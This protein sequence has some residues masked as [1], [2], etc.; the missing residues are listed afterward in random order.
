MVEI[1]TEELKQQF[2]QEIKVMANSA[3][4]TSN[5]LQSFGPALSYHKP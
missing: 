3:N 5:F 2:D 4:P 1:S